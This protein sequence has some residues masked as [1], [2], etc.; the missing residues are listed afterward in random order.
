MKNHS[1]LFLAVASIVA[2]AGLAGGVVAQ[3]TGAAPVAPGPTGIPVAAPSPA[4]PAVPQVTP[5]QPVAATTS[6]V[7]APASVA[8]TVSSIDTLDDDDLVRRIARLN[9]QKD[10]LQAEMSLDQARASRQAAV[11]ESQIKTLELQSQVANGGKKPEAREGGS[12]S[13]GGASGA[14]V[15]YQAPQPAVRSVYGYGPNGYAEI[16]VGSDKILAT[17]GTVLS[18]GH[19][20]AEIGPNGVVLIKNGRRQNLPVR[21]S[22]GISSGVAPVAP[23]GLP[24]APPQN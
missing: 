3:G 7:I 10:V 11:L 19:R 2:L 4:A 20:V 6:S 14:S 17:P 5:A 13:T 9:A 8:P 23:V 15:V 18:S 1:K 21:G 24:P 22:A 16:Y 12:V